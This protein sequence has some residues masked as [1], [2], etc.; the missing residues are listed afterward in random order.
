MTI[1]HGSCAPRPGVRRQTHRENRWRR[2]ST[3]PPHPGTIPADSSRI[4]PIGRRVRR[5]IAAVQ[6]RAR[7]I[8]KTDCLRRKT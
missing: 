1:G 8:K 6:R 7:D 2:V 4:A 5:G 3:P